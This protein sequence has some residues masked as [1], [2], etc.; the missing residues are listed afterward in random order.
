MPGMTATS[1][2]SRVKAA[3]GTD[4]QSANEKA[5]ESPTR[6]ARINPGIAI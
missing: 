2:C 3:L 1:C 6:R 5:I 4:E